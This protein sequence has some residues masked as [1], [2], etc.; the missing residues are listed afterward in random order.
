MNKLIMLLTAILAVGL[1]A[2]PSYGGTTMNGSMMSGEKSST[3]EKTNLL[4]GDQLLGLNVVTQ[5]NEVIGKIVSVNTDEKSGDVNFVIVGING[6]LGTGEER[7]A[8]PLEDLTINKDLGTATL[9][10]SR[11]KLESAPAEKEG[12]TADEFKGYIQ[13][14][15]GVA[16]AWEE[17]EGMMHEKMMKKNTEKS[18]Y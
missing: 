12:M 11:D 15:Y 1:L 8:I 10:V 5:T 16:P 3:M 13:E 18:G 6:T 14:H 2:G 4:A 17:H 7:H 9:L